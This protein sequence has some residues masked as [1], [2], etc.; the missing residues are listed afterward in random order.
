MNL[1]KFKWRSIRAVSIDKKCESDLVGENASPW[2][3][4]KTMFL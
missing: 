1:K 2:E 4:R 3:I